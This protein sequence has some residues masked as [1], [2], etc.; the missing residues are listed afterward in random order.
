MLQIVWLFELPPQVVMA[1]N[2]LVKDGG[3]RRVRDT[4]WANKPQKVVT[5]EGVAKGLRTILQDKHI[6]NE[7]REHANCF[8]QPRRLRKVEHFLHERGHYAIT[9]GT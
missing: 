1:K 5:D 8:F 9:F 2:T 3:S 6:D 7:Y 4:V